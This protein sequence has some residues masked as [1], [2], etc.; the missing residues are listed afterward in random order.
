MD[1]SELNEL[2]GRYN[3]AW[4]DQDLDAI[5]AMHTPDMVFHNHTAGESVE[6]TDAV[7]EH[8]AGIFSSYPDLRFEGTALKIGPDFASNEWIARC[9]LKDGRRAEWDG[10]DIFTVSDG[11]IAR[12]DVYS[13]SAT[14]RIAS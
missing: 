3:A 7:R 2:L 8:I 1:D 11:H 13:G 5:I 14:P 10:V 4:N 9:T 6:G 12:K